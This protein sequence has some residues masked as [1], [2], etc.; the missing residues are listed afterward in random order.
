ML[1][2]TS[3]V[4]G[5]KI[6]ALSCHSFQGNN[7]YRYAAKRGASNEAFALS[8]KVLA[9]VGLTVL[10]L[11]NER[12]TRPSDLSETKVDETLLASSTTCFETFSD[13]SPVSRR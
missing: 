3:L 1:A 13:V 12:P 6:K 5:R 4:I 10:M 7:T 11:L 2:T 9:L 8:K